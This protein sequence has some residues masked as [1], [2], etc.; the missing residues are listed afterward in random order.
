M[1]RTTKTLAGDELAL[2]MAKSYR[3]LTRE[4]WAALA[5]LPTGQWMAKVGERNAAQA[6]CPGHQAQDLGTHD[7]HRR[8][9]HRARCRH[10]DADMS[11]DSGD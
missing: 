1:T 4:E 8:G 11:Y 10:C 9:W 2:V 5:D 3:D 7:E 6:A